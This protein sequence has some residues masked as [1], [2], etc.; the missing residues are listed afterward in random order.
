V[1]TKPLN[2]ARQPLDEDIDFGSVRQPP[3][4]DSDISPEGEADKPVVPWR[5]SFRL[6]GPQGTT[7]GLVVW[8]V[9]VL[10]R[11]DPMS[12]FRPDL[13]YTA[14]GAMRHGVSRRHALLKPGVRNLFLVDQGSTNGTW[15]NGQR[16]APGR[17]YPLADGDRI[18]LGALS[19]E[20]RI[21][22]AP[23]EGFVRKKREDRP[24]RGRRFRF[25]G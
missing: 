15:V 3:I 9:T 13:D 18:E 17:E 19:M 23:V 25:F 24:M 6:T 22:E 5:V 1:V 7:I 16:L 2:P 12:A 4:P 11:A 20:L 14:Y 10:G 21:E 8:R